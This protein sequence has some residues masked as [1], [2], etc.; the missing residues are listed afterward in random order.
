MEWNHAILAKH[1]YW[2]LTKESRG[3]QW[4]PTVPLYPFPCI[5]IQKRKV[6]K[7]TKYCRLAASHSGR[8]M[9]TIAKTNVFK[10]CREWK[11][12]QIPNERAPVPDESEDEA[13]AW[14][15]KRRQRK[16]K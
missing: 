6:G 13:I 10:H 5:F 9:L 7:L 14:N 8:N 11:L 15:D 2:K 12:N 3:Q 16:N 1:F 4:I